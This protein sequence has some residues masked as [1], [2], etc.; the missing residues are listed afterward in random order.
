MVDCK[1]LFASPPPPP[2]SGL[3]ILDPAPAKLKPPVEA[4]DVPRAEPNLAASSLSLT[5]VSWAS[6]LQR[7]ATSVGARMQ[8]LRWNSCL[9]FAAVSFSCA[10]CRRASK[11]WIRSLRAMSLRSA[12][13]T[14]FFRVPFCSTSCRWTWVSCSRLRSRK[15]IFF[16]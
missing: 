5:A 11:L 1:V 8:T 3:A 6:N 7:N 13:A 12:M 16:C 14:S 15:A 10:S 4:I 9:W 2:L